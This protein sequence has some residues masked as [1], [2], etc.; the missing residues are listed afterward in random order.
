[1]S[2]SSGGL[3]VGSFDCATTDVVE[4]L[5]DFTG[6]LGPGEMLTAVAS[7]QSAVQLSGWI[8]GPY[9]PTPPADPTPLQVTSCTI[10]AG[11]LG[12]QLFTTSGTPGNAYQITLVAVGQS[13]RRITV[14]VNV[15]LKGTPPTVVGTP[16][17]TVNQALAAQAAAATVMAAGAMPLV[18]GAFLGPVTAAAD[19]T[20]PLGLATKE[21]VDNAL[22]GAGTGIA[23][24][25][26]RAEA[27]E[28]TNATAIT[29]EATN[30]GTAITA[31]VL[32]ETTR[33]EAAEAT[34]ATAISTE[35]TRAEAA[36]ATNATAITTEATNRGTAIST[37]V[38]NRNA[39]IAT[40]TTRAEAAEVALRA[41]NPYASVAVSTDTTL[42]STHYGQIVRV[43]AP[44]ILTLG[45]PAA[46]ESLMVVTTWG[47]G[48]EAGYVTLSG[49]MYENYNDG[50]GT[51]AYMSTIT[52]FKYLGGTV[53]KLTYDL[54]GA[55]WIVSVMFVP[56]YDSGSST[57]SGGGGGAGGGECFV[58]GQMVTM[59]DGTTTQI[60]NV[61]PG[62][63]V[64]GAGGEANKVIAVAYSTVR[65]RVMWNINDTHLTTADHPHL[66]VDRKNFHSISPSSVEAYWGQSE[67]VVMEG[68]VHGPMKNHGLSRG[69]VTQLAV[70]DVLLGTD[71]A[72][73]VSSV[74]PVAHHPATPLYNLAVGGSHTFFV[75]GWAVTGWPRE[76]DFD[77]AAWKVVSPTVVKE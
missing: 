13:T 34:N 29:T 68:G 9:P 73:V 5:L 32:T 48:S 52:T 21:Y 58:A 30:R 18:G 60:E 61:Q 17:S 76:D 45:A 50:S 25:T 70:G 59:A 26:T 24:E 66:S 37:E 63:L 55:A 2:G 53:L 7:V 74:K 42:G 35:T 56:S 75:D 62:M 46:N 54:T 11:S 38:T 1:M 43:S 31:A 16:P 64:Q 44:C 22:S 28:A 77:Y 20:A 10:L 71:G 33:A 3:L 51:N 57:F 19:P 41:G 72:R 27:A 47:V 12:V 39:A 40:E 6:W 14:C 69:R 15:Q 65:R 23:A 4:T 49:T 67:N 8:D 36:E